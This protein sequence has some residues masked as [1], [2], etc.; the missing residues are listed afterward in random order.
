MVDLGCLLLET[1][2][3]N[4]PSP[5]SPAT[6]A[7]VQKQGCNRIARQDP[8]GLT[9]N[10]GA[11]EVEISG[12]QR[13]TTTTYFAGGQRIAMRKDGKV[14]YLHGDHLGSAFLSSELFAQS[15]YGGTFEIQ[16]LSKRY[17]RIGVFNLLE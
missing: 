15:R 5:S 12:T 14:T 2:P 8:T 1:K 7:P 9:V 11:V 16:K 3:A 13:L 17:M 6:T 10:A 4:S